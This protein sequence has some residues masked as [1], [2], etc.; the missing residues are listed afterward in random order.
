MCAPAHQ[1][2]GVGARRGWEGSGRALA[3]RRARRG[4]SGR[5]AARAAGGEGRGGA[6]E[7]ARAVAK[8]PEPRDGHPL[9]M[10]R[11]LRAVPPPWFEHVTPTPGGVTEQSAVVERVKSG[12][13]GV[14]IHKALRSL[15]KI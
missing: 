4:C 3:G 10:A 11:D 14:V 5:A 2:G 1:R 6:R 7:S 12:N 8:K 13:E 15:W 9:A